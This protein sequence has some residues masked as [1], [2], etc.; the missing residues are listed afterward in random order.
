MTDAPYSAVCDRIVLAHGRKFGSFL[1]EKIDLICWRDAPS[2]RRPFVHKVLGISAQKSE[3]LSHGA[4]C[5]KRAV[6]TARPALID[7]RMLFSPAM[8][9]LRWRCN[10][11]PALCRPPVS[12]RAL[13]VMRA[14]HPGQLPFDG[15]QRAAALLVDGKQL[16]AV[17]RMKTLWCLIC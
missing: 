11:L 2:R 17:F 6:L 16:A 3:M 7:G 4:H 1:M 5:C 12:R 10:R 15:K 14:S 8:K 9:R 13:P